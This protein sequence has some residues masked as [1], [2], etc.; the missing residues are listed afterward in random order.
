MKYPKLLQKGDT[1]GIC[2]PSSGVRGVKN[3]ERFERLDKAHENV[4]AMGYKTIETASVRRSVKCVSA[5]ANTRAAEFMSLYENADVAA[6]IPPWG[7]EF[8]MDMLPHLNFEKLS[9]LPPKWICGYS[10][11]STLMFPL[12]LICDMATIHGTN[13]MNMVYN[14]I[15]PF[16]LMAFEAM[17]KTEITQHNSEYWG[18]FVNWDDTMP[19]SLYN[20]TEKTVWKSLDG[21]TNHNFEGRMIGGCADTLCKLLGTRFAPVAGF[22]EKYKKD[23][24]IWTLESAEMSAKDIY[25]TLWQMR[26]CGWFE[27]CNGFIFGRPD[28]YSERDDFSL[29][30]ALNSGLGGLGFP[31]IYDADIGHIPP[32]MQI[33]NGS[34]GRVEF[35]DGKAAVRQ[36]MKA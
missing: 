25:R 9:Q 21:E 29:T 10:D 36:E 2:A 31:V 3:Y 33:V 24:I 34:Y 13:F 1:I 7:G 20:L 16:D 27:R 19:Q 22:I 17:S 6:V 32:Q 11:L 14:T 28:G 15:H 30:D 12:T 35:K 5:D 26:E 4:L 23:G 18:S 8:L